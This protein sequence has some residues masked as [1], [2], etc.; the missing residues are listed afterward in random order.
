MQA[1]ITTA[2][3]LNKVVLPVGGSKINTDG[4]RLL[5]HLYEYELDNRSAVSL[6]DR[7]S[8][9][10]SES[11]VSCKLPAVTLDCNGAQE[12]QFS[13]AMKKSNVASTALLNGTAIDCTRTG[14]S[15]P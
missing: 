9:I 5:C 3:Q 14:L 8:L 11:D 15:K 4:R 12:I 7:C 2:D 6:A 1:N 10:A 13:A